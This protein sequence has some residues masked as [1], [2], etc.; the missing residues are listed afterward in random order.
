MSQI[1]EERRQERRQGRRERER[2]ARIAAIREAAARLFARKGVEATTMEE[3]ADAAELGKATLYHYFPTKQALFREIVTSAT[4]EFW[5]SLVEEGLAPSP[6]ADEVQAPR[7][8][9]DAVERVARVTSTYYAGEGELPRLLLPLMAGGQAR[10]AE[11]LGPEVAAEV[12]RAHRPILAPLK[13]VDAAMPLPGAVAD[14]LT[15][16]MVGLAHRAQ[17]D[18][19]RDPRSELDLFF[20]LLRAGCAGT[21]REN[22]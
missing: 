12:M 8:A 16:L 1:N 7:T 4:R 15:T 14:L 20:K 21:S 17:A 9:L 13:T 19:G 22:A 6:D 10:L 3:V 2:E 11:A 18:P 5:E